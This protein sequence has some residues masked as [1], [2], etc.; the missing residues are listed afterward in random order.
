LVQRAM[1]ARPKQEHL[2]EVLLGGIVEARPAAAERATPDPSAV[3]YEFR[4]GVRELLERSIL[5]SELDKVFERVSARL[6]AVHIGF[7]F[8]A[9][10]G[11]GTRLRSFARVSPA[12]LRKLGWLAASFVNAIGMEFVLV[13][14][15]K[16]QMGS[17]LRNAEQP[18]HEVTIGAPFYLGK[19]QV[20]H[21][22]WTAVMGNNPSR[23]KGDDRLPVERVSWDDCQEFITRLNA[24][25]DGY[26]YRLPSEAEWEYACRAGTTGEY[27]GELDEMAWYGEDSG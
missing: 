16:F 27:A 20:T 5:R 7:D 4:D 1:F 3:Q 10:V 14:A 8:A 12:L 23:F 22:E 9:W 18:I 17:K 6:D 26:A 19:Y 13:P 24:R 15:G 11:D 25:K 2:A 21:G